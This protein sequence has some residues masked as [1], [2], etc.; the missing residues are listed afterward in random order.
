[1]EKPATLPS[2]RAAGKADFSEPTG[3]Q[4]KDM[5][6]GSGRGTNRVM[7]LF[8]LL[9]L[10]TVLLMLPASAYDWKD[11]DPAAQIA[12]AKKFAAQLR[13][14]VHHLEKKAAKTGKTLSDDEKKYVSLTL[15]EA[16]QLEKSVEAFGKNQKRK[17]ENFREKAMEFCK[18]RGALSE[19][20][21]PHCAK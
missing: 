5:T 3:R 20:I 11:Q 13:E 10:L 2:S 15:A 18:K 12:K 8:P 14:E 19:K 4:K 17:A 21:K 16:E 6:P 9:A 7:K 1:M